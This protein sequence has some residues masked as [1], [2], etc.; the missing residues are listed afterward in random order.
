MFEIYLDDSRYAVPTLYLVP[1][2]DEA[3]AR[4]I[5]ARML[6]ESSHHLGAEL[7]YDGQ[8]LAALGTFAIRPRRGQREA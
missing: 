4:Q 7:C 8:L 1:A 3:T 5:A 6:E 2:D